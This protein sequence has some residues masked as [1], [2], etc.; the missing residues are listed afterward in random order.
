MEICC[1]TQELNLRLCN[2]LGG[3]QRVGDGRDVQEEGDICMLLLLLSRFSRVP[4]C[5][6][7]MAN[8]CCCMAEI[9]PILKNNYPSI[10]NK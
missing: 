2:N 10:K 7:S 3:L 9:K 6:T 4:L 8:L 1:R 5:V